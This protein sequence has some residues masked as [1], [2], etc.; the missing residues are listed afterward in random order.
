MTG[1]AS[2]AENI[3]DVQQQI[4][5]FIKQQ[6]ETTNANIAEHLDVSYEAVRQQLRQLVAAQLVVSRKRRDEGQRA[7]RPT[8]VYTLSAAGDHL[9]PKAYDEL[10]VELID[11]LAAALGPEALRQVLASFTDENVRQW[12]HHL[13]DK[14]LLER[15]EALKGIYLENDAYMAV[16]QDEARGELRLVERNCPFLNVASRRPALCSVTVSTLSRLLGYTVTRE[17]RF[18]DGDGR[19][20]FRVHLHQPVNAEAFR[21]AYEEELSDSG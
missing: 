5:T 12:A 11:T 17:K 8:Q 10:A 19:C 9:F 16:S 21:F 15:L 13:Q 7:G 18:Q 6:G 14:S 4:L 2:N 3:S 1:M 20:V